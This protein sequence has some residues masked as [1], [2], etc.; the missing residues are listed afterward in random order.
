MCIPETCIYPLL[1]H[2]LHSSQNP[3]N[4]FI[5]GWAQA[6]PVRVVENA[7]RHPRRTPNPSRMPLPL[8]E[9]MSRTLETFNRISLMVVSTLMRTYIQTV[10]CQRSQAT[11]RRSIDDCHNR[12]LPF[13]HLDSR[14]KH[15]RSLYR[16][17]Q[18]L[19]KRSR[20]QHQWFQSL[21]EESRTPSAF[22]GE[23][24]SQTSTNW[25][26]IHLR[27]VTR[28]S[29]TVHVPSSLTDECVIS[30]AAV[31]SLLRRMTFP[32]R[33]TFFCR[34]RALTDLWQWPDGRLATMVHWERGAC[35]V[36]SH[37]GKRIPF[38]TTALIQF[39]QFTTVAS[40]KCS[41]VILPSQSTPAIGLFIILIKS[42]LG[43]WLAMLRPSVR[44]PHTS[45][46]AETGRKSR[47]MRQL[48]WQ[49]RG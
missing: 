7:T 1:T 15:M 9:A 8:P 26:T 48:G 24:H 49:T 2:S 47:G 21:K 34:R 6:S 23:S 3:S 39:R 37:T 14:R 35:T 16:Q 38:L 45:E 43:A 27:L 12:D 18:M 44:V 22:R 41:P 31:L 29:T 32:W 40:S 42:M 28:T 11:G 10:G 25:R 17:M 5:T 30:L 20:Y 19:R 4:L 13:R 33:Q 46:M 36:F